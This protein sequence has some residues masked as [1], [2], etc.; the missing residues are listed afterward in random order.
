MFTVVSRRVLLLNNI[1]V[2]DLALPNVNIKLEFYNVTASQD[3]R[4]LNITKLL[5]RNVIILLSQS[6]C[7]N[8]LELLRN[9]GISPCGKRS[10]LW[11]YIK[12]NSGFSRSIFVYL[13]TSQLRKI[14]VLCLHSLLQ[15]QA[16]SHYSK[17]KYSI[18]SAINIVLEFVLFS[19]TIRKKK[20][21]IWSY[22]KISK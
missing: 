2:F 15:V 1:N 14:L 17:V 8:T 21:K 6:N 16:C 13:T 11:R 12:I 20:Q 5:Q 19:L 22:S 7:S 10:A 3:E 18:F 9:N 4:K